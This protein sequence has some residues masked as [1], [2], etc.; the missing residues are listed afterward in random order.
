MKK[1]FKAIIVSVLGWQVRR[2]LKK[3]PVK[4]VAVVGSMGKTSTKLAIAKLL[5]TRYRVCYQH[6]N[7]NDVVSVPLV[8]FEQALPNLANPLAWL[9]V[10]AN[11]E[12][13]IKKTY[14]YDIV[15]IE[16]GTDGPGQI[17]KFS[18]YLTVD[19]LVVT[20]ITPEHMEFFSDMEAVAQEELSAQKYSR[21]ILVNK[22]LCDLSLLKHLNSAYLTYSIKDPAD[23]RLRISHSS[24]NHYSFTVVAHGQHILG[25]RYEAVAEVQLYSICAA[26]AV[27]HR[28]GL[29][30]DQMAIGVN[31]V[32]PLSGR[33]QRLQ[34]INQSL[35]IDDTYNASPDAV[36][37]A[38]DALYGVKA[39]QRIAILGN[40]NELGDFS[41]DAHS[42]I[43]EYCSPR[44]L[45]LVVTIGRDANRYLAVSAE[46][47]GCLVKTFNNP[48]EAGMYVRD[49]IKPNAVVLV[50]GSQNGVF[51]EEAI[52]YFLANK[53]DEKL[54]VRQSPQ[55]LKRKQENLN[56]V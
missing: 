45:D 55:W 1:A 9:R 18:K 39:P 25:A 56:N 10:I 15:C 41:K 17:A 33:M 2:L 49:S 44:E 23:Y 8:F 53:K 29:T 20:A 3:R 16:L 37:A 21:T 54:L 22:D 11:N 12:L 19:V 28:F 35:I 4:V 48:Y 38:L 42:K 46:K 32:E 30:S 27:A 51:A 7:Y 52:K 36:L 40:M 50:K 43:G 24:N 31:K 13:K 14:P 6:G 26:V 5:N 47:R 34:G